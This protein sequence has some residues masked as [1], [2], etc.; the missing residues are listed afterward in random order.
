[1][2]SDSHES[3]LSW[4]DRRQDGKTQKV[5]GPFLTVARILSFPLTKRN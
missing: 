1:M 2:G 5:L 3:T 4:V